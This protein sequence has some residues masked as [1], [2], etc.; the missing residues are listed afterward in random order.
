MFL[1]ILGVVIVALLTTNIGDTT[2]DKKIHISI[3]FDTN[4]TWTPSDKAE[5]QKRVTAMYILTKHTD[6][7]VT[8]TAWG[9]N[10]ANA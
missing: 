6:Y 3:G 8:K 2:M 5:V 7:H 9:I 10:I 4:C 1:E